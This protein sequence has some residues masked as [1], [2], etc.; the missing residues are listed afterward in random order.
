MDFLNSARPSPIA[1]A[2]YSNDPARLA[3]EMNAF[4]DKAHLSDDEFSGEVFGLV[5]PHAGHVYSG[6]TA[7]YAYRTVK[8]LQRDMVVILSPFH[9]YHSADVVTTAFDTYVTPLGKVPVETQLLKQINDVIPLHQVQHDPEHAIEIQL[10]FLQ[11]ALEGEFSLLPLMVRTR[12]PKQLKAIAEQLMKLI[13]TK[14][15]L[16]IASTDLSHFHSLDIAQQLD[17]EML[18]RIK[19]MDGDA[20]LAAERDGSASACGASSVAMLLYAASRQKGSRAYILNYSTSAE[21]TGDTSSVV[22]Y[23]AAAIYI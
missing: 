13:K 2:W 12:D 18:R 14:S 6:R 4:I 17:A 23:G 15:L 1:G 7:G 21:V 10:P 5:A 22:G 9:Q 19:A 3:S 11:C 8:G 20:V 16:M